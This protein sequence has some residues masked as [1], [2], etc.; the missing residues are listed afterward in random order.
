MQQGFFKR[1][2]IPYDLVTKKLNAWYMAIKSDLVDE[3]ERIKVEAEAELANMEEN[4]DALLYYQL[5]E[6][7]HEI[8]LSYMKSKNMDSLENAYET[9][10]EIESQGQLTGMLEYYFYFFMGMYE[11][12][13]KE[14][15]TAI[16][17]YRIAEKKLF[18]VEDEIERAEFFFKVAHVYYYMKQTYFSLNY[19]NRA[20]KIFKQYDAYAVQTIRCQNIIAGNLI[21]SLDY[22][23]ALDVFRDTL[24][25][26][27]SVGADYLIGMSQMNIGICYD[28]IGEYEKAAE[29]LQTS[30][31]FFEKTEHVFLTK[32]LFN[33]VNVKTKQKA[34]VEALPYL[35]KGQSVAKK[36]GDSEYDAKFKI[37]EGLYFSDDE[38]SLIEEAFSYLNEKRMFG[39]IENFA[40]RVADYFYEK[41][42]LSRSNEYYRL[43]I[44]ARRKIKKGEIINED[45]PD[46]VYSHFI[47]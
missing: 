23:R 18:E 11:F 21:D 8:M 7:R 16:S 38:Y 30:L 36:Y 44:E 20:L 43:S 35:K 27:E 33:I 37:I 22:E 2:K 46:F 13:R 5:L 40:I 4:Q 3:A 45:Q 31:E 9:L 34:L 15:T 41:G 39:D 6:F 26:A 12:R 25:I 29:Y 14:L 10:R 17:A 19:A 1:S 32:T 24:R 28:Y 42:D 47:G